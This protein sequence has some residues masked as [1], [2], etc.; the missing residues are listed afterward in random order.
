MQNFVQEGRIITV[1][2]P[3]ALT[4]GL[5][6]LVGD[7]FGVATMAADNGASAD[8]MVEGVFDLTKEGGAGVT[9]AQGDR[10]Y[11][12]NTNKRVVAAAAGNR[13]IG[14]AVAAAA[15]AATTARVALHVRMQPD[16][17]ESVLSA[18][19][20]LDFASIA[21]AASADLTITVAG[22]AVGDAVALGLPAAPAAGLVFF[23]FV[24]AANTVTVRAMNI[25]GSGV[26]AALATYRATV[27]KA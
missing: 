8:I 12:D 15:D 14:T 16:A 23:G 19:A 7:I 5:G 24:S 4:S 10:V 21:A 22:A 20:A 9:F 17:A 18:T 6:C 3:Y 11:W 13:Y 26:D 25:T 2:A 1:T 27:F